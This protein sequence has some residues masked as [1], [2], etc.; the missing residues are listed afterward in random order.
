MHD[1]KLKLDEISK[2]EGSASLEIEVKNDKVEDVKFEITEY[3]RFYAQ[4]MRGKPVVS[5]PQLLSRI[6]GTCSNAHLLASIK[7]IENAL[8][9][10]PSPQTITL[11]HLT[12]YGLMIR[13]HILHLGIFVLP[14]F[15]QKN[16]VFDFDEN[17]PLQRKMLEDT[18]ALKAAGN[19]LSI[20]VAGRSVHAPYPTIGGFLQTPKK[21]EVIKVIDNLE[22]VRLAALGFIEI[23]KNCSW[24]LEI[25]EKYF[26][27]V[28]EKF[29]WLE[30]KILGSGG[31][32]IEG[33]DFANYLDHV[34]V[35]YSQA[36]G[37]KYKGEFYIVGA[38]A[39]LNLEKEKLNPRTK[40]DA[41]AALAL[42]P[43]KNIYHNNLAQAIEV[44]HCIDEALDILKSTNFSEEKPQAVNFKESIGIGVVEAPRGTLYHKIEIAQDGKIKF[45][46]II[47]PTGQNQVSIEKDIGILVGQNLE[48]DQHQLEHEIEK[49]I[50][51]YDP[52]MSCASHF[53]KCNWVK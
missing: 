40:K 26:A 6:C 37:W 16:S 5:I 44:L 36:S 10:T 39:R 15:Y 14:D 3:K 2:I 1:F 28:G 23:F 45:G 46:Q 12:T 51:A 29:N 32:V 18:L 4:A 42:F 48:M 31:E 53:L 47:I 9:I 38:L 52:C 8:G 25:A 13:D 49:L 43:S 17:D 22:K 20:L 21:E 27:L 35:P 33:F 30:G 19:N 50:R 24:K 7:S 41:T 34:V 11:R